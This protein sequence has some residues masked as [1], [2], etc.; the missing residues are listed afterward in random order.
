MK[1]LQLINS[2]SW[3]DLELEKQIDQDHLRYLEDAKLKG[4]SDALSGNVL[5]EQRHK[6]SISGIRAHYNNLIAKLRKP[7]D[8]ILL[9]HLGAEEKQTVEEEAVEYKMKVAKIDSE[10][11]LEEPKTKSSFPILQIIFQFLLALAGFFLLFSGDAVLLTGSFQIFVRTHWESIQLAI[12]ISVGIAFCVHGLRYFL[13]KIQNPRTRRWVIRISIVMALI[14]FYLLADF[15]IV[16]YGLSGNRFLNIVMFVT[17]NIIMLCAAWYIAERIVPTWSELHE[18]VG[19]IKA[20]KNRKRLI[21]EKNEVMDLQIQKKT[22]LSASLT[23]KL[24]K[25][26]FAQRMVQRIQSYYRSSVQAYKETYL[27]NSNAQIY[28]WF[29]EE[30]PELDPLEEYFSTQIHTT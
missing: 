28:E 7:Y 13:P 11:T 20:R 27:S 9:R 25:I 26:A 16:H 21:N 19:V 18:A 14:T 2:D 24:K 3:E 15:R 12:G 22:G 5:T 30:P 23:V 4:L 1:T 29:T 17:F 6:V 8:T 10:V